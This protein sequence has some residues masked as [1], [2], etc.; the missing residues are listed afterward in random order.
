MPVGALFQGKGP[1]QYFGIAVR[2]SVF[3][4]SGLNAVPGGYL[5]RRGADQADQDQSIGCLKRFENGCTLFPTHFRLRPIH[6]TNRFRIPYLRGICEGLE[7]ARRCQCGLII[8]ETE[9]PT[10]HS[11]I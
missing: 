6:W 11:P 7:L 3:S 8:V 2:F 5:F 9:S 1:P 10:M 4:A